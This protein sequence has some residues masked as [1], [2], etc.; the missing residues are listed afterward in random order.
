M[1]QDHLST[2]IHKSVSVLH[3]AQAPSPVPAQPGAAEPH[4]RDLHGFVKIMYL[5][6]VA[7]SAF[8]HPESFAR[9]FVVCH[10]EQSEGSRRSAQD[11]LREGSRFGV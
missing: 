5:V 1:P 2:A 3:V 4:N 6:S 7:E 11:K 8:C 9:A 10:P